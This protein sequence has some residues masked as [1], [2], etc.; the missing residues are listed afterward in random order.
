MRITGRV[1]D[2]TMPGSWASRL[3]QRRFELVQQLIAAL[4]PSVSILDIGGSAE[5]WESA[6]DYEEIGDGV[7]IVLLNLYRSGSDGDHYESVVGDARAMPQYADNQ[8]DLVFSNSTIEHVGDWN[9]QQRMADEVRRVG[10]RY[11]VQTP[12]RY[13]PIE[14]HYVFP[15]FHFLP[16]SVRASLVQ[17]FRLGWMPRHAEREAALEAVRSIRLLTKTEMAKLFPDGTVVG[18]RVAGLTKSLIVYG[19]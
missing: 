11:Y 17:R 10:R 3:R 2:N 4:G 6:R 15:L 19:P 8:F 1:I 9:D 13:F 5:F 12:S 7:D 18:E 16:M 14:P